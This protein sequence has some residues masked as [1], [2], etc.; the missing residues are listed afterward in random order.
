MRDGLEFDGSTRLFFTIGHPVAQIRMPRIMPPVFAALGM[1]AAWLT[2]DIAPGAL[3]AALDG[4]RRVRNLAGLSVTIPHKPDALALADRASDRAKAAGAANLLRVEADGSLTADIVDGVGF[5]EGL[6]A[7]G[8]EPAGRRV[9]LVGGGGAGSAIAAALCEAGIS[10]LTLTDLDPARAD[11]CLNRLSA[12]HPTITLT[13]AEPGRPPEGCDLAINASPCGLKA[14]D[15]LPFDPALLP[16]G[17][18]V[19]DVIMKPPVTPLLR[20]AQALGHPTQPGRLMLD[21][22]IAP[23]LRFFGVEADPALVLGAIPD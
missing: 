7:R 2:L 13:R 14:E 3:G 18:L 15:P 17:A 23:L 22:Q 20:A 11:A 4:L 5:V 8:F 21:H 10:A 19:A 9:W 1:N 6:R 16:S 12:L